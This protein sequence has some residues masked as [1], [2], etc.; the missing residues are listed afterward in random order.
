MTAQADDRRFELSYSPSK[1]RYGREIVD[2]LGRELDELGAERALILCGEATAASDGLMDPIRDALGKRLVGIHPA[3]TPEKHVSAIYSTLER[4]RDAQVDALVAVG[5]GATMD[6]SR[7]TRVPATLDS[8]LAE[9]RDRIEGDEGIAVPEGPLFPMVGIPTTLAGAGLSIVGGARLGR[10][11]PN[12]PDPE[13]SLGGYTV[14]DPSLMPDALIYDPDL[15]ATTPPSI[16]AGSAMNGFDK[17]LEVLYT[18]HRTPITDGTAVRG[19]RYLHDALPEFRPAPDNGALE[20]AIIGLILAQYGLAQPGAYRAAIIHAF[21][22]GFSLYYDVQQGHVHGIVA[23]RVLGYVF[24]EVDGRRARIAE[25]LGLGGTGAE[26]IVDA[27]RAIRDALGLPSRLRDLPY[28]ERSELPD[29][30]TAIAGDPFMANNPPGLEPDR[31]DI[32]RILTD[33][34]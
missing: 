27:V 17:A 19:L 11:Y 33:L 32:E 31:E 1:I 34:W 4:I 24:E 28:V 6:L 7:G 29:V 18:R 3:S 2:A 13:A 12:R 30:A 16:L 23:P 14:I 26:A 21:G 22:H 15:F 8:P 10:D 5:G 25:G 9:L 20:D